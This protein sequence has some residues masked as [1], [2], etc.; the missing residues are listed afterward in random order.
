MSEEAEACRRKAGECERAAVLATNPDL[1]TMY[2]DLGRQWREMAA[3]SEEIEQR[4]LKL[5]ERQ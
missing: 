4:R 2:R 5:H 3:Q 1:Q